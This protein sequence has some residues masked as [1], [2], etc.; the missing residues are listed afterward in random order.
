[1]HEFEKEISNKYNLEVKSIIPFRDAFL[2][3]TPGGRKVLKKSIYSQDD[4]G[5]SVERQG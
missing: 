4:T 2:I 5:T 1:M 3:N